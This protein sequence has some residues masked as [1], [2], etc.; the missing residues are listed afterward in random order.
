MEPT[1]PLAGEAVPRTA[2]GLP[3]RQA[4]RMLLYGA[5]DA[6]GVAL[7][8]GDVQ[9]VFDVAELD[10]ITVQSIITWI[11]AAGRPRFG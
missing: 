1:P 2:T 4:H 11:T 8:V 10:Y 9:A 3:G 6:A 7:E 5:L